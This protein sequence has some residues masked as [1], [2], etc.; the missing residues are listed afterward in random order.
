M[1]EFIF[2]KAIQM[3]EFQTLVIYFAEIVSQCTE[4]N[5]LI[6]KTAC[7]SCNKFLEMYNNDK[8]LALRNTL[9][10]KFRFEAN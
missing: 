3:T 10:E 7:D 8:A 2:D 5:P 4:I 1:I 6:A 9:L